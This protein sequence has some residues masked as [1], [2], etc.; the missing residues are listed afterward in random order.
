MTPEEWLIAVRVDLA[1]QQLEYGSAKMEHVATAS[2]FGSG[3]I[4][5]IA[6]AFHPPRTARDSQSVTASRPKK[7]A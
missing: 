3:T 2:G 5:V 1:R 7:E 6:W 4:F